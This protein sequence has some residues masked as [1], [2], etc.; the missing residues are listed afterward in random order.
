[1]S[2]HAIWT[3]KSAMVW[4]DVSF[5]TLAQFAINNEETCLSNT[6]VAEQLINGHVATQVLT[7]RRL[8][9]KS[10]TGVISLRRLII[11]VRSN[12]KLFTRENYICHDGLPYDYDAAMCKEMATRVGT[13]AFWRATTGP[14]AFG[15]SSMAHEL[16][17]KLAGIHPDQRSREDRLP[18]ALLDTIEGWLDASGADGLAEWSHAYLAHAGGPQNRKRVADSMVTNNKITD[19]IR[20][21]ARVAEAISAYVLFGSGRL[22]SLMPTAQFDQFENLDKPLMKAEYSKDAYALWDS[23]SNERDRYVD[24]VDAEL[25]QAIQRRVRR[26]GEA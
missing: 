18:I 3:A 1:M 25:T 20:V 22:N 14:G 8:T 26:I 23:L 2:T 16:F 5:R 11:D 19:A 21:I 4:T 10:G 13:G 12:W 17:D 9:D 24:G 7:I 15:T 6:L